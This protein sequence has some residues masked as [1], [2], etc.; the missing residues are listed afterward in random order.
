MDRITSTDFQRDFGRTISNAK[1]KPI[2]VT[3]RGRDEVV[4]VD[5]EEFEMIK[6]YYDNRKHFL[7]SEL[8]QKDIDAI[9]GGDFPPEGDGLDHLLK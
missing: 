2:T 6:A 9:T 8:P 7:A 1:R 3:S 5:A 4:V